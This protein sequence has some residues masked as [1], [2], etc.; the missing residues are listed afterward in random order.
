[1]YYAFELVVGGWT[2]IKN[3]HSSRSLMSLLCI[4]QIFV[5][6]EL[7]KNYSYFPI[8]SWVLEKYFDFLA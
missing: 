2:I 6:L 4:K 1:M 3:E 7:F 8:L 5:I